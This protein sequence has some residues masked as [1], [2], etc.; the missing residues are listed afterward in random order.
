[1]PKR[2]LV[3]G[4]TGLLGGL[5]VAALQKSD[6]ELVATTRD[7]ARAKQKLGNAV[8]CVQWDYQNEAFPAEALKA[9]Q[10][11]TTS[12]ARILAPA[13]GHVAE[14]RRFGVHAYSA[15]RSSLP[16]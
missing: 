7:R 8:H 11:S 13:A 10:W 4:A 14:R 2:I 5:L 6:C 9:Y 1:M 12:W 15:P 3:T 16:P